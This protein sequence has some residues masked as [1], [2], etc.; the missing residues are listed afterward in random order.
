MK[1]AQKII[2]F[3]HLAEKLKNEL[4]HSWTSTGRQESVAE[5]TWRVTL[6]VL[7]ISDDLEQKIDQIKAIKMA[8]IHDIGEIFAGDLHYSDIH[9]NK[10][11]I[12][13]RQSLEQKAVKKVTQSL[14][15]FG[16]EIYSLWYEFSTA[17]SE[18]ARFVKAIDMLEVCIQ[19]N[20]ADLRSWENFEK[21]LIFD[22]YNQISLI[23][24][25][26]NHIVDY[27][28]KETLKKLKLH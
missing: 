26:I 23:F 11:S 19:H 3:S 4:R 27:C 22:Y 1:D 12:S 16:E 15:D 2:E 28:K 20:E 25:Q 14:G 24:S 17:E 10:S 21:S 6:L 13:R 18:E 8:L 7:L 5:H 9:K